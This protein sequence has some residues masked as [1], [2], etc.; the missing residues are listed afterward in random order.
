MIRNIR[1][2]QHNHVIKDGSRNDKGS[3]FGSGYGDGNGTGNC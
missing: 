3:G 1:I 2:R